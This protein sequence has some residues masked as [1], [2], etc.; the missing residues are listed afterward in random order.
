MNVPQVVGCVT[1]T[2]GCAQMVAEP[3]KINFTSPLEPFTPTL[4]GSEE[5]YHP[6]QDAPPDDV[7]LACTDMV[8]FAAP[9]PLEGVSG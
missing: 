1:F 3:V 8:V 2:A 9:L 6:G 7:H 4:E 5:K